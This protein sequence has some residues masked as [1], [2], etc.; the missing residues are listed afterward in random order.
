MLSIDRLD[1]Q[2]IGLLS[3]NARTGV[4]ELATMLG[5]SRNTVQARLKRLEDLGVL[6]GFTPRLDLSL[7]GV[8]VEAFASLELEQ[9]RL[10]HVVDA[11]RAMPYV[12]EIHAVTGREDLLVRVAATSHQELQDLIQQIHSIPGVSRSDTKLALT[13]PL[14]YRI[15]PLLEAVT[16]SAG[17]GRSTPAVNGPGPARA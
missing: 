7:A 1:A 2:L 8:L 17:F 6:S 13:S 10:T 16:H 9:G 14:P 15:Q 5:I 4:V 12:L 3:D 11:L